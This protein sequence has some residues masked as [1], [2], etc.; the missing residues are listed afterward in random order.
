MFCIPYF[1]DR[2]FRLISFDKDH[3][4]LDHLYD[5][6]EMIGIDYEACPTPGSKKPLIYVAFCKKTIISIDLYHNLET[7]HYHFFYD[8]ESKKMLE[9]P[10]KF[11]FQNTVR[12][13]ENFPISSYYDRETRELYCF[14]RLG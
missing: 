10:V 14:Y 6:N 3:N 2:K 7:M 13:R 11:N 8:L 9:K 1:A 12:D 4:E 5:I